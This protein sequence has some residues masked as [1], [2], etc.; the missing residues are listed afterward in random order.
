VILRGAR[1]GFALLALA[2]IVV[3][4]ATGATSS[5]KALNFVSFFTIQGNF[6]G[7]AVL[8]AGA[9]GSAAPSVRRDF[10]RGAAVF[11]LVLIGIVF[12]L[13]LAKVQEDL[14]LTKPWVDTVLHQL[15]PVV[16]VADWVVAPISARLSVRHALGWLVFPALWT[17]YTLIRGSVTSWYPYPFIDPG[18]HSAGRV[19]L[20]CVVILLGMLV[21]I[22]L[23]VRVGNLRR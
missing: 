11:Y 8:L 19:A 22:P 3:Q 23:V 17:A 14:Q 20:N 12:A 7:I 18:V 13:L 4:F 1:L 15:M 9:L 16:L 6:V 2:A 21:V 5:F 10:V